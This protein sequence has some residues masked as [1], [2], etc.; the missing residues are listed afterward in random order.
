MT[1]AASMLI[2]PG[3]NVL[4]LGATLQDTSMAIALAAGPDGT[5]VQLDVKRKVPK[6]SKAT[7]TNF[8]RNSTK[9]SPPSSSVSSLASCTFHELSKIS[10]YISTINLHIH[11]PISVFVCDIQ[12]MT[13][14]DLPSQLET[15][16]L[17]RT[18]LLT[19][20]KTS[21]PTII[22]KSS[23]LNTLSLR[24]IHSQRLTSPLPHLPRSSL[25]FI[26]STVGVKSYRSTIPYTLK[27]SDC[28]LEI[29]CHAGTTTN[30]L[31]KATQ[32]GA[33][34][35]DIG[36]KI[37]KS[38]RVNYPTVKFERGDAW[39][40]AELAR[41]RWKVMEE[42]ESLEGRVYDV[43]YLDVGGLSGG[44]GLLDSLALLDSLSFALEPRV[45]II[46]SLSVQRLASS[47]KPFA[48]IWQK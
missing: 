44:D 17:L 38:A 24:L 46:K 47:L 11:L 15:I 22:I 23:S 48:R 20:P 10:D 39:K 30:L 5:V 26:I 36:M 16:T 40:T 42:V 14:A 6:G 29:G 37:L 34:G 18:L 43:I 19:C 8:G 13:G 45:I 31:N 21:S 4:E 2:K 3:D 25:P 41:I 33:I 9:L 7:R 28:V 1:R 32:G 27:P 35:V 12:A